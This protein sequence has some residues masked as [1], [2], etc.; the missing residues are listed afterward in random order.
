MGTD[1]VNEPSC[2]N[3]PKHDAR[4]FTGKDGAIYVS[5]MQC[6]WWSGA[7]EE[8]PSDANE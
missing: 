7:P 6:D 8:R 1:T 4:E 5:C 2:P 3:N